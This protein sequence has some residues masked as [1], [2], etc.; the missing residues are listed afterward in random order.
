LI[1]KI[2]FNSTPVD[3]LPARVWDRS[4]RRFGA[5][6]KSRDKLDFEANMTLERGLRIT[7]DWTLANRALIQRAIDSHDAPM[8][9]L[10][11]Q[12]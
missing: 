9:Q 1:N 6:E 8:R 4:G 5:T 10:L 3:L 12:Y 7:V 11:R 2:T